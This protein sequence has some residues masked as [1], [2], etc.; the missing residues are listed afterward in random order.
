[1]DKIGS[2]RGIKGN[3]AFYQHIVQYV[4]THYGI[5]DNADQKRIEELKKQS[6]EDG[7][8]AISGRVIND[9]MDMILPESTS[10]KLDR[11]IET[12]KSIAPLDLVK[13]KQ[14]ID[15]KLAEINKCLPGQFNKNTNFLKNSLSETLRDAKSSLANMT[16]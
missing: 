15:E 3:N 10:L 6:E 9:D 11:A 4:N 16:K 12:R 1:M 7:F 13:T 8:V 5:I 2:T 14:L